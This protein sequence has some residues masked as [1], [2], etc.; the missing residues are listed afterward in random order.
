MGV[1]NCSMF[2]VRYF[3][4]I[5]VLQSS[6]C[7]RESWLLYLICL[8]SV[9]WW[10]SCSSSR[11]HGVVCGLWLWFFLMILTYYFWNENYAFS[12]SPNRFIL[13]QLV[14]AFRGSRW[15]IWHPWKIVQV[16]KVDQISSKTYSVF[17]EKIW[18][19]LNNRNCCFGRHTSWWYKYSAYGD[20]ISYAYAWTHAYFRIYR[21][22]YMWT[23]HYINIILNQMEY[24]LHIFNQKENSKFKRC[25]TLKILRLI[26]ALRHIIRRYSVRIR[27]LCMGGSLYGI[28]VFLREFPSHMLYI[29][30]TFCTKQI[31]E[32]C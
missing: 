9:S 13:G 8:P 1:C 32:S 23:D 27:K 30:I 11:C 15:T 21:Q 12:H 7:G 17:V 2:F 24:F 16:C 28:F 14:F 31:Q 25:S 10:L 19:G 4:S 22:T 3:M 18:K 5:L 29:P 26:V 20:M 6:W